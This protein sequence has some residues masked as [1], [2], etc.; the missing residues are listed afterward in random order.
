MP[1]IDAAMRQLNE[2]GW[3]NNCCRLNIDSY[4]VK[5]LIC[6]W[7]LGEWAC[8]Q[9]LADVDLTAKNAGCQLSA[10]TGI[11]AEPLRISHRA[12]KACTSVPMTTTPAS[13]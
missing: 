11:D 9:C 13:G 7:R 12:T 5:D 8:N 3:M 6:D 2:S 10:S 1:N 4:L